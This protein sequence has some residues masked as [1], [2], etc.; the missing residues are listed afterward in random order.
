MASNEL[1]RNQLLELY[2]TGKLS[3]VFEPMKVDDLY[4]IDHHFCACAYAVD[5]LTEP[6]RHVHLRDLHSLLFYGTKADRSG[7]MRTGELRTQPHKYGTPPNEIHRALTALLKEYDSKRDI[8]LEDI[9]DFHVRFERIHPFEDG[10][11]RLGRLIMLKECLRHQIVP[12]IIDD[13][14]RGEYHKGIASWDTNPEVLTDLA[15]RAQSHFEGKM[16]LCRL[17]QYQRPLQHR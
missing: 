16:D 4:E 6:L 11:S 8:T 2:R 1:T 10:N 7:A 3:V 14:H 9:L 5:I 13:K 17:F 15:T 12:F